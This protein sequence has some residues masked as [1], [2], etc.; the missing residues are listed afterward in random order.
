MARVK[1][2]KTVG[3]NSDPLNAVNTDGVAP[4]QSETLVTDLM[5][6]RQLSISRRFVHTLR[7]RGDLVAVRLGTA[8][9]FP[10][11]KNLARIMAAGG[12]NK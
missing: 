7:A 9:R 3:S 12:T 4:G 5:L 8:L 11:Q 6:A 10:L 1:T 2:I